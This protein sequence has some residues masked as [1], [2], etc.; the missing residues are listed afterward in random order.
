MKLWDFHTESLLEQ[1][2]FDL[3]VLQEI[4]LTATK[5]IKENESIFYEVV[6]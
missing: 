5:R 2:Q 4:S 6:K 1:Y 3:G